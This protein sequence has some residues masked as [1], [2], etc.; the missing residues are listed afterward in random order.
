MQCNKC[1]SIANRRLLNRLNIRSK[2]EAKNGIRRDTCL[3]V[4]AWFSRIPF[5]CADKHSKIVD[6]SMPYKARDAFID[7]ML[8]HDRECT[9]NMQM[10]VIYEYVPSAVKA[11]AQSRWVYQG[12]TIY[13]YTKCVFFFVIIS[14]NGYQPV[15]RYRISSLWR[16]EVYICFRLFRGHTSWLV[17][18]D[19]SHLF[20]V[21]F[22]ASKICDSVG[23][24]AKNSIVIGCTMYSRIYVATDACRGYMMMIYEIL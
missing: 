15:I 12:Y 9:N 7:N 4:H 16:I 1:L 5:I 24:M 8:N 6:H 22:M 23:T 3:V 20:E 10:T 13:I 19:M 14:R 17:G 18:P 11:L 21:I 2:F